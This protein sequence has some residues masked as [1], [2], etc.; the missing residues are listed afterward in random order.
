MKTNCNVIRDLLPLY[1]DDVCSGESRVLV[2]A[3]LAECPECRRALETMEREV[4]SPTP[5]MEKSFRA[6]RKLQRRILLRRLALAALALVMLVAAVGV[7]A[8][9]YD[10]Y[11]CRQYPIGVE[12][13]RVDNLC[14]LADG[15]VYLELTGVGHNISGLYRYNEQRDAQSGAETEWSGAKYIETHY[16]REI[17]RYDFLEGSHALLIDPVEVWE[18]DGETLRYTVTSIVLL[19]A[20]TGGQRFICNLD[21]E[22]PAASQQ[23]EDKVADQESTPNG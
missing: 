19:D 13:V 4:N 21:D 15:R 10:S 6:W 2:D 8:Y 11:M 18:Q 9:A 5:S 14:R 22:L 17:D 20:E 3:H 23:I 12:N 7:G 16:S 1:R